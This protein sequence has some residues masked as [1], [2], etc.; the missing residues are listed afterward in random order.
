VPGSQLAPN[1]KNWRTHPA[2]QLDALRGVLAEVGFAG[3][4]LA[5]ELADGSLQ[6]I[7]GHAR[8]EI[9]GDAVV[10]VLVTDLSEQEAD[11]ILATFDPIGA[12]AGADG[13]KLEELLRDVNTGNEA[14]ATMLA[15]LAKE[16]GLCLSEFQPV[17][18]EEQQRLD[19]KTKTKCP[20]CGHEF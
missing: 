4:H 19:E 13:A 15:D 6:L 20:E 3:A 16:S 11:K 1:P 18:I 2:A 8:A 14:L 7:D 10:P 17:G 12:M 5:R 9:V